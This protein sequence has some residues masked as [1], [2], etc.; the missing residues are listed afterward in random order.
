MGFAVKILICLLILILFRNWFLFGNLS[1]GDW[2]FYFP[3]SINEILPFAL[4]DT[5]HMGMGASKLPTLWLEAYFTTTIQLAKIVPWVVYERLFWHFPTLIFSFVSSFYLSRYFFKNTVYSLLASLIYT[6][7]TY[8]LMVVI[9]N[10]LGVALAYAFAPFPL[11]ACIKLFFDNK[12]IRQAVIAGV[13]L[14]LLGIFDIRFFYMLSFGIG[15]LY[16]F[17][18]TKKNF[19]KSTGLFLLAYGI[20]VLMH[21]FWILPI[22]V[23]G[24][25]PISLVGEEYT[26]VESVRFFSFAKLETAMSFLHPNWPEN[27]FGKVS[28]QKPEFLVLTLLGIASLFFVAKDKVKRP[29][30]YMFFIFLLGVFLAK[31]SNEPFGQIYIWLFEYIPGFKMFRDPTKWYL[32]I[33]LSLSVLIPYALFHMGRK[34][35]KYAVGFVILFVL[36]WCYLIRQGFTMNKGSFISHPINKEY[37]DFADT[38]INDDEFYRTLWL[39]RLHRY[40]YY[41]HTHPAVGLQEFRLLAQNSANKNIEELFDNYNIRYIVVPID[42][43]KELF[44]TDREYDDSLRRDTIQNL[45]QLDLKLVDG[46]NELEV[47]E[48]EGYKGRVYSNN[49]VSVSIVKSNPVYFALDVTATQGGKIIFSENYN[50][51]WKLHVNGK[52]ID[53]IKTPEGLNS[54]VMPPYTGTAAI[55]YSAQKWVYIGLLVSLITIVGSVV[56]VVIKRK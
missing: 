23:T 17:T 54:F 33:A 35:K 10:Q 42:T 29:L 7:N 6:T 21:L 13:L 5:R 37:L 19:I 41:S 9:G 50:K 55:E 1:S 46:F 32:L 44:I 49:P 52:M 43:D 26:G 39:P 51:D 4:W 27:I 22:L 53:S 16:L 56:Y 45:H 30:I 14:G 3:K 40:G 28:F 11:L 20:V 25:N 2:I 24:S 47:L 15:A 48:N 18:L 38:L 31:G 8:I 12:T 36:F 34:W